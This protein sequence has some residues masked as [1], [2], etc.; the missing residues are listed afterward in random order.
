TEA[1]LAGTAVTRAATATAPA[2]GARSDLAFQLRTDEVDLAAIVDVVDL[3]LQLVAFLEVVLDALDA[4][5]GDL[6]DV[7]QAIGAGED[8]DEGTELGDLGHAPVVLLADLCRL[9]QALDLGLDGVRGSGVLGVDAHGA[10]LEHLDGGAERLQL[11][12]L[13]ASW[14][15]DRADLVDGDL[16]LD[17][18]RGVGRE[19]RTRTRER[20]GHLAEYVKAPAL[21]LLQRL[22]HDRSRD[23]ANL[24]VHLKRRDAL[25]GAGDLEVHVAQRVLA[26]E[27]VGEDL[28]TVALLDEAH[29]DASHRSG[30]RYPSVHERK[31]AGADRGHRRGAVGLQGLGDDAYHVRELLLRGDGPDE[32]APREVA[33]AQLAARGPAQALDLTR[34]VRREVVVEHELL[35]GLQ[36]Q[37]VDE[38]VAPAGSQGGDAEDLRL[39]PREDRR[40]VRLRQ[41][42][43]LDPDGPD[44]V[45]ATAVRAGVVLDDH[46]PQ[47]ALLGLVEGGLQL[48]SACRGAL[49]RWVRYV[50]GDYRVTQRLHGVRPVVL[51]LR[52]QRFPQTG[53]TGR[54]RDVFGEH[55][56]QLGRRGELPLRQADVL[57]HAL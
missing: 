38:A 28:V 3:D 44:L 11:A 22:A 57:A 43:G 47:L 52:Q 34:G 19:L 16:D 21:G 12:D 18:P 5:L 14:P 36:P 27:D 7:K 24:D 10:V 41:H 26:A 31:R 17:D 49:R 39:A 13:L 35:G 9:R 45:G 4:L 15:D 29:S 1:A 2:R 33:V 42:A 32:R 20:L 55:G 40:A 51:A 56:V 25:R 23:A 53:G 6:A 46:A 37:V 48:V 54:G 8:V 30:D 50:A